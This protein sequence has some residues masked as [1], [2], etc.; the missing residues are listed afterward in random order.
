MIHPV[1]LKWVLLKNREELLTHFL[2]IFS[3]ENEPFQFEK[4]AAV[5]LLPLLQN[6]SKEKKA[7]LQDDLC[8]WPI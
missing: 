6:S 5:L 3:H 2:A 8:F 1:V 4:L 7:S